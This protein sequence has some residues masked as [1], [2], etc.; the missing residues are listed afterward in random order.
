M[1]KCIPDPRSDDPRCW[2]INGL[3]GLVYGQKKCGTPPPVHQEH[4]EIYL[5]KIFYNMFR[6]ICLKNSARILTGL[7]HHGSLS[8]LTPLLLESSSSEIAGTDCLLVASLGIVVRDTSTVQK[9]VQR[10]GSCYDGD[11]CGCFHS[12]RCNCSC[13]SCIR[14]RCCEHCRRV[15]KFRG[16]THEQVV[17]W[18]KLCVSCFLL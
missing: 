4:K 10:H 12:C 9:T 3:L 14:W 1:S 15:G 8:I 5:H 6:F 11:S 18:V 2:S 17:P 16:F 7:F 13:R